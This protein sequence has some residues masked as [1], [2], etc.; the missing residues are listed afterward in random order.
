M[1]GTPP[2]TVAA[3][4]AATLLTAWAGWVWSPLWFV[5]AAWVAISR[6][7]VRIHH[8]SDV[9]GGIVV[10]LVLGLLALAAG[11]GHLLA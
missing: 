11:A 9:V 2:M 7:M 3:C 1:V 10:G 8:A 5:L 6:A 4:F